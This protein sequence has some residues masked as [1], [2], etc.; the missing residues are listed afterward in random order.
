MSCNLKGPKTYDRF[1][2]VCFLNGED[3]G[4]LLIKQGLACDCPR[5]SKDVMKL[6][7]ETQQNPEL[8]YRDIVLQSEVAVTTRSLNGGRY[9]YDFRI[10]SKEDPCA[11]GH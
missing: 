10:I 2:A 3:I 6:W 7:I 9:F 5:Y 4:A 11:R 1:V 8:S